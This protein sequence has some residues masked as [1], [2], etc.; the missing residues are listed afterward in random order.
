MKV[1]KRCL[2]Y[3]ISKDVSIL[4]DVHYKPRKV[5]K[6]EIWGTKSQSNMLC[7]TFCHKDRHNYNH[8]EQRDYAFH[9]I[10]QWVILV[11]SCHCS[12]KIKP[13]IPT[14]FRQNLTGV[15][16]CCHFQT[17]AIFMVCEIEQWFLYTKYSFRRAFNCSKNYVNRTPVKEVTASVYTKRDFP[18]YNVNAR[19]CIVV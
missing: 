6:P 11:S 17:S 13:K 8:F 18:S 19:W 1:S 10:H 3:N 15:R 4:I 16:A 14:I 7:Y 5:C 2:I 9:N 12:G